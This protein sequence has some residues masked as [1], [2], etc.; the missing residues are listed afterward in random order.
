MFINFHSLIHYSG[1][2]HHCNL[3]KF[4][5]KITHDP[6][7]VTCNRCRNI[8]YPTDQEYYTIHR[9]ER[10]SSIEF[11]EENFR[12]YLRAVCQVPK[13]RIDC[14]LSNPTQYCFHEGDF[15]IYRHKRKPLPTPGTV[16]GYDLGSL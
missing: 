3:R 5:L 9:L 12:R 1:A 15:T 8:M 14:F 16:P 2:L 10:L 11:T 13:Y 4:S 7:K 6:Q